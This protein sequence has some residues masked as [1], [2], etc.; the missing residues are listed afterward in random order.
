MVERKIEQEIQI[1]I[2]GLGTVGSGVKHVLEENWRSI[3]ENIYR[4]T[5]VRSVIR[6]KKILV[7]NLPEEVEDELYTM[8]FSDIENDDEI[9]I[10][11]ELIGGM[12]CATDYMCR[13]LRAGKH[14][15][16]ANK[17]A[18]A[19]SNGRFD[20]LSKEKNRC[21]KY[22]ASVAGAIPVI[23]VIEESLGANKITSISG[24]LNG[25]TNYILSQ[26]DDQEKDFQEALAD[27]KMLGFAESNAES[28]ISGKDAMYKIAIL[29][30]LFDGQWIN[31]EKIKC[32]GI[33]DIGKE[34]I[35]KANQEGE[36]IKH[37]AECH[38]EYGKLVLSVLPVKLPKNH[39]FAGVKGAENAVIVTCDNA[40]DIIL[41]GK[42]AGSLPTASAV[43]ADIIAVVGGILESRKDIFYMAPTS[44]IL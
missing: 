22:E 10:V 2:L 35:Q 5:G 19:N 6:I 11:V 13:A 12:E 34:E 44:H 9:Q 33:E 40:G 41:Q 8:D 1:A 23:R 4:K 38:Y 39:L 37:I 36:V 28:D 30:N 15:V 20:R 7:R 29:A 27:A 16:T 42:G 18:I 17:L 32:I 25:T 31:L 43:V 26:M 3:A 14:V 24:I 21:F